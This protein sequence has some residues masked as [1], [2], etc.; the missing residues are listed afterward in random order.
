MDIVP[1][2]AHQEENSFRSL[3]MGSRPLEPFEQ[4]S[5]ENNRSY[6]EVGFMQ[7]GQS[8]GKINRV[9]LAEDDWNLPKSTIKCKLFYQ[10]M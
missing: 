8:T 10:L 4:F 2:L 9:H 3:S 1:L 6:E 5:E 7:M